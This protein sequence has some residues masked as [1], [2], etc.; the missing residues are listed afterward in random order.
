MAARE[1]EV[2][3]REKTAL[4]EERR[5]VANEHRLDVYMDTKKLGAWDASSIHLPALIVRAHLAQPALTA[6]AHVAAEAR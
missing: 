1:R 3:E 2:R 6:Y 5:N 4:R